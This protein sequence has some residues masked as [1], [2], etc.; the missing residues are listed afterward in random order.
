MWF[1]LVIQLLSCNKDIR[2]VIH[3]SYLKSIPEQLYYPAEG[4]EVIITKSRIQQCIFCTL[5]AKFSQLDASI[6][7]IKVAYGKLC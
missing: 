5:H 3:L 2:R 1:V 6:I 7:I 4:H